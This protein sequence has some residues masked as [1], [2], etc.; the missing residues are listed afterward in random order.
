MKKASLVRPKRGR[1]FSAGA[2]GTMSIFIIGSHA[3]VITF[4][5]TAG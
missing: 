3:V 5:A 4:T 2:E 1:C